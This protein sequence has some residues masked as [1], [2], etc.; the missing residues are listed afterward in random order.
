MDEMTEQKLSDYQTRDDAINGL[1]KFMKLP[2]NGFTNTDFHVLAVTDQ[3]KDL[4]MRNPLSAKLW[5]SAG[6]IFAAKKVAGL[7]HD[8]VTGDPT[9]FLFIKLIALNVYI[10]NQLLPRANYISSVVFY[11][12]QPRQANFGFTEFRDNKID[13]MG[14]DVDLMHTVLTPYEYIMFNK[15][16]RS[17]TEGIVTEIVNTFEDRAYGKTDLFTSNTDE[18]KVL[19]NYMTIQY[20]DTPYSCMY[21]NLKKNSMMKR[22]GDSVMAGE[23]IG[24]VGISGAMDTPCLLFNM[25]ADPGKSLNIPWLHNFKLSVPKTRR[26]W[27]NHMESILVDQWNLNANRDGKILETFGKHQINY[28]MSGCNL[29]TLSFVKQTPVITVE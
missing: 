4:M 16:V 19:G 12:M 22:M 28:Q 7:L 3:L 2:I 1:P 8:I 6:A 10:K 20:K 24:R 17:A 13:S 18:K 25:L 29:S 26:F 21:A 15:P 27:D 5:F 14:D 9:H 23:V 11:G